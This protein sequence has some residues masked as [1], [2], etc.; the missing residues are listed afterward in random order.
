MTAAHFRTG[1][2]GWAA[3][4]L[5]LFRA[6]VRRVPAPPRRT[7]GLF[8]PNRPRRPRLP[9]V[10]ALDEAAAIAPPPCLDLL[11]SGYGRGVAVLPV[12]QN[13]GRLRRPRGGPAR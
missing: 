3:Q 12:W 11:S 2:T 6:G 4:L 13:L 7:A 8:G 1:M 5:G 9:L 10:L